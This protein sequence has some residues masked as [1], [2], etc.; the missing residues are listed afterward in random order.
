[1][2]PKETFGLRCLI[3]IPDPRDINNQWSSTI[4]EHNTK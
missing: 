2:T 1:M 4:K 3:S